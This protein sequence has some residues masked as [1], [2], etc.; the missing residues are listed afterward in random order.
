MATTSGLAAL[1]I[2]VDHLTWL[3]VPTV[4]RSSHSLGF[5][6]VIAIF[7]GLLTRRGYLGNGA[8][9]L[10][11]G[12]VA[13]SVVPAH[14]IVDSTLTNSGFP[15]WAPISFAVLDLNLVPALGLLMAALLLVLVCFQRAIFG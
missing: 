9:S 15:L 12:A 14:I 13:A 11:V 4:V 6:V 1:L 3:G 2:D 8:P 10:L 5:M 7:M